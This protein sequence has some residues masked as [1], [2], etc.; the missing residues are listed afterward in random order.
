MFRLFDKVMILTPEGDLAYFG[1][2]SEMVP[3]LK[4]VGHFC[5]EFTNPADFVCKIKKKKK[6]KKEENKN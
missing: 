6:P 1:Q 3:F 5:D 4:K 2:A